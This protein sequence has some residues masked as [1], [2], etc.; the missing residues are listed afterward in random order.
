MCSVPHFENQWAS[1]MFD[2]DVN[3]WIEMGDKITIVDREIFY[4]CQKP[5]SFV[6]LNDPT[7][8][9]FLVS[10]DDVCNQYTFNVYR[11]HNWKQKPQMIP[12]NLIYT[13][14]PLSNNT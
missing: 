8:F 3:Y 1:V 12:D 4:C 10:D 13:Q 6:T 9:P 2:F 14:S 7:N 5:L 11:R